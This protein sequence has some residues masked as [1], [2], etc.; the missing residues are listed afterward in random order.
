M[1]KEMDGETTGVE[2]RYRL[3]EELT[4]SKS[5]VPSDEEST[6]PSIRQ[7]HLEVHRRGRRSH[8]DACDA[9]YSRAVLQGGAGERGA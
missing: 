8:D 6:V 4:A 5:T 9:T 1:E 3:A 2:S 7:P